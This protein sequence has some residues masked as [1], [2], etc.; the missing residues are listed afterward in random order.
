MCW[1]QLETMLFYPPL[2]ISLNISLTDIHEAKLHIHFTSTRQSSWNTLVISFR[3]CRVPNAE[4]SH[5][6]C[7]LRSVRHQSQVLLECARGAAAANLIKVGIMRVC[8]GPGGVLLCFLTVAYHFT[9][10]SPVTTHMHTQARA[11]QHCIDE[12]LRTWSR[13][14]SN[15]TLVCF[16]VELRLLPPTPPLLWNTT[17]ERVG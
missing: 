12:L 14:G 15:F 7:C 4:P 13:V 10:I 1:N 11:R 9:L 6:A 16:V 17:H 3:K 2:Y 5:Q 8:W